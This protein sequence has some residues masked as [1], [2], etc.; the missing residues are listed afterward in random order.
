MFVP[1]GVR[2]GP[3]GRSGLLRDFLDCVDLQATATAMGSVI[4]LAPARGREQHCS[5]SVDATATHLEVEA[6]VS[7]VQTAKSH[8][9]TS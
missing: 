9:S 4:A 3:G 5:S 1:T 8:N 2:D 7:V 6:I